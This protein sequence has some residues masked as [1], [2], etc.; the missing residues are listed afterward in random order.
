M[1]ICC[2]KWV[3]FGLLL[4]LYLIFSLVLFVLHGVLHHGLL[5]S[6]FVSNVQKLLE[7]IWVSVDAFTLVFI[8]SC[9]VSCHIKVLHPWKLSKLIKWVNAVLIQ[10]DI[11]VLRLMQLLITDKHTWHQHFF[12]RNHTRFDHDQYDE[13]SQECDESHQLVYH[14]V[15]CYREKNI[16]KHHNAE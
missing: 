2:Q 10:I 6:F 1:S 8:Q 3:S 4:L 14:I 12:G 13:S 5:S 7:V 16:A 15:C 9:V 11:E